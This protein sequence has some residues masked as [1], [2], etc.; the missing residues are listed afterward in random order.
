MINNKDLNKIVED[1]RVSGVNITVRDISYSLLCRFY[2]DKKVSYKIAFGVQGAVNEHDF[3]SYEKS[4]EV[5]FINAYMDS[6]YPNNSI[7]TK[8][9][10]KEGEDISFEENKAYM[11]K[12]KRDTEKAIE[13]GEI[14]KKDG[15]KI[16][17][18]LSVKLND[19]FQVNA[20][21]KDQ[22]VQV[23]QKYDEEVCPYCNHEVARRP[24]TK[25]EAI[26]EYNLIENDNNRDK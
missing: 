22:I 4:R 8:K 23:F 18:D 24:M 19:K 21:V 15:L 9:K 26:K 10:V 25:E 20:E 7:A 2:E 6:N 14:E 13:D 1:C 12:L 5:T 16:L 3:E 17:A 11:L